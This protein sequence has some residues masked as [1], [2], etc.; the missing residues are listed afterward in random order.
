MSIRTLPVTATGHIRPRPA[1][2]AVLATAVA[3][4]LSA[5][6][7]AAGAADPAGDGQPVPGGTI[8]YAHD[9]EPPCLYGGWVQQAYLSR[10]VLDSLVSQDAD[11][12][13]V[14]WLATDWSV[15]DD[16]L[17]WTFTLQEGVRFTDGTPLDAAA[18]VRNVEYWIPEAGNSTVAAYL[19]A[20]YGGSR[21]LDERTVELTLT[22]PYSPLLSALSQP[23]FGIQSPAALERG[24]EANCEEPIG[25]GPFV[26][27]RWDRGDSVTFTRNPDYTSAPANARH[28]GPAHVDGLV[29]RFVHDPVARFGALTTDEAQV[30]YDVPTPQWET[31]RSTYD[32][33][34]YITP[35]RPVALGLNTVAGPFA[36]V[37]VR[38]AFAY[39]TDREAAVRSAFHGVVPFEGN[40]ALSQSTPGYD[41]TVADDYV[42]DPERAAELLDE[43]GWTEVD[44]EGYRVKEGERLEI[45]VVYGAGSI[46]TGEGATALQNIQEQARASGFAVTLLPATRDELFSGKYSG[47]E[48]YDA[49]P[50][51]WTSPTAGVLLITF[52]QHLP[53]SPNFSNASFYNDPELEGLIVEANSTLDR[54]EQDR[55]YGRAQQIV[56]EQAASLGLWTQ[57]TSLA[58]SPRLHDVWLEQSQGAPVFHDAVFVR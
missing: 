16:Q 14:P 39:A 45:R 34:Q 51:Y 30:I 21:A 44:A 23:Y 32:V 1:T 52:R 53:E 43:S 2:T 13:I 46:V 42:H 24:Q 25:S 29:W 37:R 58:V 10:Q 12:E 54:A 4:V 15:T 36:D 38:Q 27:E 33:Q 40:G 56:S 19:K 49:K 35:G 7:G 22:R 18:V 57:T 9:Q 55:L 50:G 47:P 3:A 6:G 48:T 41:P 26:V 28:Q 5:C 20:Y 11:G 17:V 31:A 8:V